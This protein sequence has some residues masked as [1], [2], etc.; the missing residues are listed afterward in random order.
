VTPTRDEHQRATAAHGARR[1]GVL[2]LDL[3]H[4]T[5]LDGP[6]L[7]QPLQ[8]GAD[9]VLLFD[10]EDLRL[11][12]A[13]R[14]LASGHSELTVQG[15]PASG[16]VELLGEQPGP[17]VAEAGPGPVRLM[18][19]APGPASLLLTLPARSAQTAWLVY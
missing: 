12:V 5:L 4:D 1:A 6:L 2:V 17:R 14:Y 8:R 15:V 7:E 9:R 18:A 3:V 10:R 11:L 19:V 13:V 16:T